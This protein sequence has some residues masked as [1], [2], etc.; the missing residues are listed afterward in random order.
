MKSKLNLDLAFNLYSQVKSCVKLGLGS[1]TSFF[2]DVMLVL[3]RVGISLHYCFQFF[4]MICRNLFH[5][6]I[7]D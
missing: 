3:D 4:S 5:M 2:L 6:L 1:Q 7:R